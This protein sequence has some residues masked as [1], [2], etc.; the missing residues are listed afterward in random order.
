M[1]SQLPLLVVALAFIALPSVDAALFPKKS[2]VTHMDQ[3]AFRK[4]LKG[5]VCIFYR[6]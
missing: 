2:N 4:A 6:L 1:L 3:K 5:E